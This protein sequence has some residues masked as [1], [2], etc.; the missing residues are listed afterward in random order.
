ME[1]VAN[2]SIKRIRQFEKIYTSGNF[3]MY[4]SVQ[5]D[6]IQKYSQEM[7]QVE[8]ISV[9]YVCTIEDA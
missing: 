4:I 5:M 3:H 8:N 2:M 9:F 7:V 6:E 1:Y